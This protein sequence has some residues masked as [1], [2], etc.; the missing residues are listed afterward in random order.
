[1]ENTSP[2]PSH[3]RRWSFNYYLYLS[4]ISICPRSQ[5]YIFAKNLS[6]E[7]QSIRRQAVGDV[8]GGG[9]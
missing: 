6:V 1:M 4:A 8:C 3:T 2:Q 7:V 9:L 5:I